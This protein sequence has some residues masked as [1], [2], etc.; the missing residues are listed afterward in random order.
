M[1]W[2]CKLLA[3]ALAAAACLFLNFCAQTPDPPLLVREEPRES[4]ESI[5]ASRAEL[6]VDEGEHG[7]GEPYNVADAYEVYSAIIPTVDH[8]LKMGTW[9]IRIDTL[10]ISHGSSLS[11]Q[12]RKEWKQTRAW[13][14]RW[15]TSS[16]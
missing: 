16:T 5:G 9:F 15:M 4:L 8:D 6:P 13:T 11:D 12:D 14:Q 1:N 3:V 7:S 10:P 2:T